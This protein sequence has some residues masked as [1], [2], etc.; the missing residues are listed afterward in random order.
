[1]T[2]GNIAAS[3]HQGVFEENALRHFD[4][5]AER[6]QVQPEQRLTS[7]QRVRDSYAF[8]ENDATDHKTHLVMGWMLG[9]STDLQ[10]LLEAQL[11]IQCAAGQQRLAA[12]A[13]AGNH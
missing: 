3:T 12:A 11:L 1:M 2:F 9:E 7:P 4:K 13:R 8:D 5:L 6:I 10:Q